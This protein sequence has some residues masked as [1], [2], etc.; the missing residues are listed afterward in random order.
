M[1]WEGAY[2][3]RK[4]REGARVRSV[5]VGGGVVGIFAAAQ[6]IDDQADR[7]AEA[8]ARQQQ[9]AT[10][11]AVDTDYKTLRTLAAAE[12]LASGYHQHKRTWRRQRGR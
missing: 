5:Y 3:Y 10:A 7:R 6:D 11:A 2:Y 8:E 12:L 4:Q 9:R 1:A